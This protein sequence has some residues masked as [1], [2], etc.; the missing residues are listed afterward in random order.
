M[1]QKNLIIILVI[2]IIVLTGM[3]VYFATTKNTDQ[4]IVFTPKSINENVEWRNFSSSSGGVV[5]FKYPSKICWDNTDCRNLYVIQIDD[6]IY[7]GQT[8]QENN[9]QIE[10]VLA[11]YYGSQLFDQNSAEKYLKTKY[12]LLEAISWIAD[13]NNPDVKVA[14]LHGDRLYKTYAAYS[15]ELGMLVSFTLQPACLLDCK[16]DNDI[17]NSIK[18]DGVGVYHE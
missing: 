16:V 9:T 8:E 6:V 7:I 11:I 18:L 13:K 10:V 5:S 2:L 4:P 14:N 17:L 12:G 15:K 3:V 1:N